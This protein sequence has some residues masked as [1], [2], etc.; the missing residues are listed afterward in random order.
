MRWRDILQ[1]VLLCVLAVSVVAGRG[2]ADEWP[3]TLKNG[4]IRVEVQEDLSF[5]VH[6]LDSKPA[7]HT[8]NA[9][10]ED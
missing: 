9:V 10:K 8:R 2:A 6:Y 4:F 5:S 1:A 3:L 7:W